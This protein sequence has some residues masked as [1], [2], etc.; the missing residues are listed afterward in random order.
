[1][2][3]FLSTGSL[4]E[5]PFGNQLVQGIVIAIL[6]QPDVEEVKPIAELVDPFPVLTHAQ[7]ELAKWLEH[8]S[9]ASLNQCLQIMLL[10]GLKQYTD[11]KFTASNNS[12][13]VTTIPLQNKIL[14][15]FQNKNTLRGRQIDKFLPGVD[16]R[17]QARKLVQ[18]GF[19]KSESFLPRPGIHSRQ[20]KK[21]QFSWPHPTVDFTVEPFASRS[22]TR[23]SVR[24]QLFE[25]L[26]KHPEP[27]DLQ[28]VRAQVSEEITGS[29]LESLSEAGMLAVWETELI[30]DP[31]E[32]MNEEEY[33]RHN[34]TPEQQSAWEKIHIVLQDSQTGKP[35]QP[36]LIYGVTGSGKTELYLRAAEYV[37]AQGKQV[38]WL[39]PEISLTP[40][41]V[42]RLMYRF[43]G[44]V[45]LVHSRLTPGERFDTWH[46]ARQGK[47]RIITGARSAMFTPVQQ[48]GL[49]IV[50]ESHDASYYQDEDSPTFDTNQLVQEYA[51]ICGAV[52]M[53]GTA[54][55]DISQYQQAQQSRWSVLKLTQRV[56]LQGGIAAENYLPP[57]EVVD[58]RQELHQ[59]NRS[60]FSEALVRELI[61]TF[62]KQKQSIL[63]L[64]RR[65]SA[66]HVF[67]RDCGYVVMCPHCDIPLT[68]HENQNQLLC[69]TCGYHRTAPVS[70][71]QCRSN[72]IRQIGVGTETV[73]KSVQKLLPDA[74]I[75]RWDVDSSQRSEIIRNGADPFQKSSI[76][77][78][79]R[80][81]DGYQRI[82]FS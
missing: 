35:V 1:M 66:T 77:C 72:A 82:G 76:R 49:I 54:T 11:T 18:R 56:A 14:A 33:T 53:F 2:N 48:I 4:V 22:Q 74:R 75:L 50:D 67:C 30:R 13:L 39:V 55:P 10:P 12:E 26:S 17:S 20:I 42:G 43:P 70:C 32:N 15:L 38:I 9:V 71:P 57:I 21:V 68:S 34:L 81:S 79:G 73:E 52:C 63:F 45:G 61:S 23:R 46:R 69:H 80:N 60:I 19:L 65:G 78:T 58:M 7:I 29:D 41:T 16:W 40:Q 51:R 6:E 44:M 31:L 27:L 28:W 59:G 47:I 5:V 62:E 24:I 36:I 8:H 37:L 64:N 3:D 25:Y